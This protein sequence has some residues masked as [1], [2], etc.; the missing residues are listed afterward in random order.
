ML[1]LIGPSF[2]LKK[3]S[4]RKEMLFFSLCIFITRFFILGLF[5]Q[6]IIVGSDG[7]IRWIFKLHQVIM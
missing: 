1:D 2:L 6:I 3:F 4:W 7:Q 5:K